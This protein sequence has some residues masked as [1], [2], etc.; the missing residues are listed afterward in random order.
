MSIIPLYYR[1]NILTLNHTCSQAAMAIHLDSPWAQPTPTQQQQ[2]QLEP[3][4]NRSSAAATVT[5]ALS[6]F[7]H[8]RRPDVHSNRQQQHVA[9]PGRPA[10][11]KQAGNHQAAAATAAAAA[12]RYL[13]GL[14]QVQQLHK[15]PVRP[16]QRSPLQKRQSCQEQRRPC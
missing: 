4:S 10:P 8:S 2:Q 7:Q 6:L 13:M 12:L 3:K 9:D 1:L 15:N 16:V 5:A 11:E 14:L